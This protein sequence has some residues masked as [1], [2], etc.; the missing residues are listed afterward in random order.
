[1]V[2]CSNHDR[3][4]VLDGL[5]S[6][7]WVTWTCVEHVKHGMGVIYKDNLGWVVLIFFTPIYNFN[8]SRNQQFDE[9]K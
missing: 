4:L 6:L 9:G 8:L 2:Y 5:W 1:M 3:G 7:K